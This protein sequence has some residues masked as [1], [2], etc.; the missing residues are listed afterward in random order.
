MLTPYV[1]T[2]QWTL[3]KRALWGLFAL[4]C[5]L[6]G[7]FA[8]SA[9]LGLDETGKV[10][11]LQ[12]AFAVHALAGGVVLIAGIAQLNSALRRRMMAA[13]RWVGRIYV[14][15]ALV[16]SIAAVAN[17]AF[18]D[19]SRAA[20]LSFA[21]LGATW[22]ATTAIG[23]RMIRA[24]DVARHREW[25]LRSFSL[26]LFF[27]TFSIWVPLLAGSGTGGGYAMAVTLSWVLNLMVAEIWIWRSREQA[28][29]IGRLK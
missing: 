14:I 3:G 15:C 24:R 10:R 12:V 13:H 29:D 23:W 27:V 7:L 21:T 26:S 5:L 6:Y 1:N 18:F 8:L 28:P 4:I 22:F 20:Q 16:A 9:G 2:D 25:M 11:S 19:V 17:A